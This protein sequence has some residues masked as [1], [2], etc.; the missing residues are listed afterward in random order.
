M[1]PTTPPHTTTSG[2]I[3][4]P[5]T[6]QPEEKTS[7]HGDLPTMLTDA[8]S[9]E[10]APLTN[11]HGLPESSNTLSTQ[12]VPIL[13][14]GT[15]QFDMVTSII[16]VT[17]TDPVNSNRTFF[18]VAV[19]AGV[20]VSLV[21]VITIA[22]TFAVSLVVCIKARNINKATVSVVS[23]EAYGVTLQDM[24]THTEESTYT[25]AAVGQ[26]DITEAKWNEAYATNIITEGN[27]AY[28]TN[29]VTQGN[30]A[31]KAVTSV[32]VSETVDLYDYVKS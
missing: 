5:T 19:T 2:T 4:P 15:E 14:G 29:F 22:I 10:A 25:Y 27:E 9:N 6:Q 16:T 1:A 11:P 26:A 24:A 32:T 17:T 23:N 28:A 8:T 30:E 12:S 3:T 20:I 21:L 7:T 31:Y 13:S 18:S